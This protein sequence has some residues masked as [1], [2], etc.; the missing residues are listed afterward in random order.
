MAKTPTL[1]LETLDFATAL[2][3][4][5]LGRCPEPEVPPHIEN[6]QRWMRPVTPLQIDNSIA[7]L[8]KR[9][10][11]PKRKIKMRPRADLELDWG[12]D[13]CPYYAVRCAV[14]N[15]AAFATNAFKNRKQSS[16]QADLLSDLAKEAAELA[17][18]Y[19]AF[20]SK[21]KTMRMLRPADLGG[22]TVDVD[23]EG[24]Q[25]EYALYSMMNIRTA[26]P[27]VLESLNRLKI[28]AETRRPEF[29]RKGNPTDA[30]EREF[31]EQLGYFWYFL[32]A[33]TPTRGV[34]FGA[35]ITEAYASIGGNE[36]ANFERSIR[37]VLSNVAERP[38]YDQFD[39]NFRVPGDKIVGM[40]SGRRSVER[41]PSQEQLD[42]EV[43]GYVAAA[44]HDGCFESQSRLRAILRIAP[45]Y[46][47][48]IKDY[49]PRLRELRGWTEMPGKQKGLRPRGRKGAK[50]I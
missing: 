16:A 33:S 20:I 3:L 37:T 11:D 24:N 7:D 4:V 41:R 23:K 10:K 45:A 2:H 12:S 6:W 15:A 17:S 34:D 8:I 19:E 5:F 27:P 13:F 28:Y 46:R 29:A 39:R 22:E 49:L 50:T 21:W 9:T 26:A 30:W 44:L 14:A 1:D 38:E 42:N 47:E 25:T 32:T 36:D 40:I 43:L 35:F 31:I 48:L 18:S